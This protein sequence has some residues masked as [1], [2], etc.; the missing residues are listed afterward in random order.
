MGQP[1]L[2]DF[3]FDHKRDCRLDVPNDMALPALLFEYEV[4]CR[5][6]LCFKKRGKVSRRFVDHPP[7][8]RKLQRGVP[9]RIL[10][11]YIRI[12]VCVFRKRRADE[13]FNDYWFFVRRLL[14]DALIER[15]GMTR[16]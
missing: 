6:D 9:I 16:L 7:Q 5:T 1:E 4:C 13:C 8:V 11:P 12:V 3:W 2:W 10:F 15:E 14:A